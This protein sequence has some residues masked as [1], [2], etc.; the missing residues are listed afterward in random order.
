MEAYMRPST[1]AKTESKPN[2]NKEPEQET[3]S[4]LLAPED[5]TQHKKVSESATQRKQTYSKLKPEESDVHK[6]LQIAFKKGASDLHIHV[7]EPPM[8][9][10]NN[11]LVGAKIPPVSKEQSEE[12]LLALLTP[13]QHDYFIE[14][15]DI[16]FVY[17][18]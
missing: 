4:Q 5:N 6:F 3:Q 17:A 15:H 18:W 16:G 11:E 12:N 13:E 2:A 8:L 9:R 7:G 14:N 10:I 1:E